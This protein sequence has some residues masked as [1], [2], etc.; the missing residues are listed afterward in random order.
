ME[1]QSKIIIVGAGIFGLTTARKLA[2]EGYRNIVVLDRHM[3]PVS[4]FVIEITAEAISSQTDHTR[5]RMDQALISHEWS[6]LIMAT[7][8]IST[9]PTRLT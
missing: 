7:M 2:S 4:P 9:L 6:A 3:P 5:F 1:K 8:T